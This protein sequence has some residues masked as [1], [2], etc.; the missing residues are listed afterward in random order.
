MMLLSK[1]SG[2]RNGKTTRETKASA[3]PTP[4]MVEA[5]GMIGEHYEA[6][7]GGLDKLAGLA[8]QLRTLEPLLD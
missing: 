2:G 4:E 7:H 1:L 6:I 5:A 8:E 3:T